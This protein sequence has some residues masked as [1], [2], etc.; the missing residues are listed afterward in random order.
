MLPYLKPKKL[1]QVIIDNRSD[2]APKQE[3]EEPQDDKMVELAES[4]LKAISEQDVKALA[5]A[6][7]NLNR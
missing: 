6:L 7:S 5:S 2:S 3:S 4:I 1:A